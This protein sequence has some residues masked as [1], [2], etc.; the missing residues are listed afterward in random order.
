MAARPAWI[1]RP[2]PA[3]LAVGA[4][5]LL[6]LLLRLPGLHQ[7]LYG[8]ELFTYDIVT[9]AGLGDL[10]A[11]VRDTSIT[12]PLHYL[13][14][15]GAQKLGTPPVAVRLPSLFAG[16]AAVPLV[17]L[18]GVRTVGRRAGVLG[19]GFTAIS[20]FLIFY[21]SEAR[22]YATLAFLLL[23]CTLALV[24]AL[25]PGASRWWW[26]LFAVT[27]AASLY[28]HYTA[29]IYLAAQALWAFVVYRERW[30]ALL[31]ANAAI[32]LAFLPWIPAYLDQRRNPGVDAVARDFPRGAGAALEA[33]VN[34]MVRLVGGNPFLDLHD[35]PGSPALVAMGLAILAGLALLLAQRSRPG[36]ERP[37][38]R[39]PLLLLGLLAA[40]LP[41]GLV[42]Y[43]L[44]G[45]NLFSARNLI[46]SLPAILLL[47][48]ALF[49]RLRGAAGLAATLVFAVGLGV[50][51]AR[52][53]SDD[54]RRP[55]WNLAARWIDRNLRPE[56]SVVQVDAVALLGERPALFEDM[57]IFFDRRHP[58]AVPILLPAAW[59]Q[60]IKSRR[61]AVAYSIVPGFRPG[62]VRPPVGGP[63]RFERTARWHGLNDV[64]VTTWVRSGRSRVA[65]QRCRP[66]EIRV[67]RLQAPLLPPCSLIIPTG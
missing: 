28:T 45:T 37:V 4:L 56:D 3:A 21:G 41:V 24:R 9:R 43:R 55:P 53:L 59:R 44:G 42:L 22:A 61:V 49:G 64:A 66:A 67:R 62:D 52:T 47:L 26:A 23:V 27:G 65:A 38:L 51:A 6:A 40:A 8:D 11:Q 29:A 31:A 39:S 15:Y 30:R 5:T 14:A 19:A 7:A 18:L 50:G 16:A 48:G 13:L 12:P 2:R 20:P 36:D 34:R 10:L 33:Y 58:W 46:P 63:W 35:L 25:S 60:V 32:A 17:Y 54:A 1:D 57:V